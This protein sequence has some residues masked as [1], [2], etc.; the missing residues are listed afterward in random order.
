MQTVKSVS[1][2]KSYRPL[3]VATAARDSRVSG[4]W[5]VEEQSLTGEQLAAAVALAVHR[6]LIPSGERR[7][8]PVRG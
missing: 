7:V 2:E 6:G 3:T 4:F 8:L 5:T 1:V